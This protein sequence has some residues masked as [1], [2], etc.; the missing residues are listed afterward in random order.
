[1]S[2]VQVLVQLVIGLTS[3]LFGAGFVCYFNLREQNR[4]EK[5]RALRDYFSR[6]RY[7]RA[8]RDFELLNE[9]YVSFS[10]SPEVL[11]RLVALREEGTGQG[12]TQARKELV[13]AM[14]ESS[15]V[16]YDEFLF[17]NDVGISGSR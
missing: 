11:R 8:N 14:C 17:G 4:R 3:G 6:F 16:K 10:E 12:H 9:A 7:Q 5:R 13:A 1:M 2:I 15:G